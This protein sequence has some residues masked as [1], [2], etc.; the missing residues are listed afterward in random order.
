MKNRGD[1]K[2][3]VQLISYLKF[4]KK[5]WNWYINNFSS[6]P[7]HVNLA[8]LELKRSLYRVRYLK[9]IRT[10]NLVINI[11]ECTASWDIY[12]RKSWNS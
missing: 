8:L 2:N 11:D 1:K 12:C 3:E 9:G 7:D 6:R 5:V 10:N 4:W